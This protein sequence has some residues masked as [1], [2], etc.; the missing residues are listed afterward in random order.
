VLETK[1]PSRIPR[2]WTA[3]RMQANNPPQVHNFTY[4]K[5]GSFKLASDWEKI[6][7]DLF[8]FC[9]CLKIN[10]IY[11]HNADCA[12]LRYGSTHPMV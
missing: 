4:E 9:K 2:P 1:K 7:K 5:Q 6:K 10:R 8:R 3:R 11:R 12:T